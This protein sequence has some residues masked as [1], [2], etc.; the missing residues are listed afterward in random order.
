ML[1]ALDYPPLPSGK[2]FRLLS[3]IRREANEAPENDRDYEIFAED[4]ELD[5]TVFSLDSPP[6]YTAISYVWGTGKETECLELVGSRCLVILKLLFGA[7]PQ[8]F[9]KSETNYLWIDQICE[10]R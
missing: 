1:Q 3:F 8:F 4:Y 9:A 5:V 6:A 7:L 2:Y 10:I